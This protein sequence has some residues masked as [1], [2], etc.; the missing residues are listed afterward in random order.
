MQKS[1]QFTVVTNYEKDQRDNVYFNIE[2]RSNKDDLNAGV[3][4]RFDAQRTIPILDDASKYYCAIIRF[5]IPNFFV[6]IHVMP[7]QSDQVDPNASNYSITIEFNGD[8]QHVFLDYDSRGPFLTPPGPSTFPD[9]KQA[10]VPYYF[11]FE[12]QHM[13]DM[14]NT[15]F[16]TAFNALGVPP[17][18]SE[19]P[20]MEFDQLNNKFN[21]LAQSDFYDINLATPINVYF[22]IPLDT[23]ISGFAVQ[24]TNVQF[25]ASAVDT[26]SPTGR[27]LHLL[28]QNYFN[29]F[30]AV[31]ESNLPFAG[32]PYFTLFQQA[33]SIFSWNPFKR[34]VL[35]S[36]T[37]PINGENIQGSGS[38][39]L[40]VITDFIPF[41]TE[42]I[43]TVFQFVPQSQYRLV[44]MVSHEKIDSIDLQIYWIDQFDNFHPIQIPWN[45]E[46]TIKLAF[47]NKKLYK[48]YVTRKDVHKLRGIH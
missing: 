8:I 20:I 1:N 31:A 14:I 43:R 19:R 41:V 9:G 21:I 44:D 37:L 36:N 42:D 3:V 2:I 47:L 39:T 7:I 34:I 15:A 25:G 13:V 29:N 38:T 27:D 11:M 40:K 22:N 48:N 12:Y 26:F 24:Q 35:V 10:N 18:G 5:N 16:E 32:D 45:Q 33:S 23:I 17:V 4:A 6:P 30:T 28:I 46:A